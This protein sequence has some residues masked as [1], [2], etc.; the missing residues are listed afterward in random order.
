MIDYLIYTLKVSVCL[1]LFYTFYWFTLRNSTFFL[2]NRLYLLTSIFLSFFIPILHFSIFASQSDSLLTNVVSKFPFVIE[3]D[4]FQPQTIIHEKY[5]LDIPTILSV[6]YFSVIIFLFFK[7]LFSIVQIFR[8]RKNSEVYQMGKIKIFKTDD[9]IPFS[10]FNTIYLP[11]AD[12]NQLI[13]AHELTHIRQIH[14]FDLIILE[15][16]SV[17]LWFNPFAVLYKRSLKLQHEY[18]ADSNVISDTNNIINYLD[19]MLANI[20]I[21]GTNGLVSQFYCKTIKNRIVMLTK[22]KTSVK[23]SGIYLLVIPLICI[24]LFA[25]SKN[26]PF[27]QSKVVVAQTDS[28]QPSIYP[29]DSNKVTQVSYY[30]SRI[31]PISKKK[32]FHYGMDFATPEGEKVMAT[33]KGDVVDTKFDTK[34]G[35]YIWVRHNNGFST[36][37]AHLQSVS[38]KV[39]DKVNRGQEIGFVGNSGIYSTGPHLHY[40]VTK[41]GKNVNPAE[42]LS[43]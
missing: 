3:E 43:K 34:L 25:F 41:N 32:D 24:M 16:T 27:I 7:L 37:Y 11:K 17:L 22:N 42:Y 23:Y 30:G 20:R 28:E 18:L 19:C 2:M 6:I 8:I 29:V 1:M 12:T 10:F 14:W 4:F 5:P 15:I 38:V 39:G 26:K 13:L 33:A 9:V 40:A 21:A 31:N 35:N 36:L